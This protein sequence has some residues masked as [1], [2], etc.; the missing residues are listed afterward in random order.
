M[1]D[2]KESITI[3]LRQCPICFSLRPDPDCPECAGTGCVPYGTLRGREIS[4]DEYE[5]LG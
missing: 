1:S 4:V 5:E 2:D 3:L